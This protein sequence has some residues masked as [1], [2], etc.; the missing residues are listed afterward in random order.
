MQAQGENFW[1]L[2]S[3]SLSRV[4]VLQRKHCNNS[5]N[6][7]AQLGSRLF[8]VLQE[9]SGLC[10]ALSIWAKHLQDRGSVLLKSGVLG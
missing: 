6:W 1:E 3:W 4:K 10:A 2:L 7:L 8:A 5:L 9:D